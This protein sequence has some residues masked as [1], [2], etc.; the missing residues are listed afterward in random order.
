MIKSFNSYNTASSQKEKRHNLAVLKILQ[1][2]QHF[3]YIQ[4]TDIQI[5]YVRPLIL[6][7]A[8]D[9]VLLRSIAK[10]KTHYC[11]TV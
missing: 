10:V 11:H 9:K 5:T 7:V 6:A 2:E 4:H 8:V 3:Y 1:F